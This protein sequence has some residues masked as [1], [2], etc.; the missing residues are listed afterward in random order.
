MMDRRREKSRAAL[1][2]ISC[3]WRERGRD[4][5]ERREAIGSRDT[6][7]KLI[8]RPDGLLDKISSIIIRKAI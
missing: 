3:R 4:G 8:A 2:L 1:S 5:G 6:V 7:P